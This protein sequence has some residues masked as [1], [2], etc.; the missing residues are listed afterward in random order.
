MNEQGLESHS[1]AFVLR[2]IRGC[3]L[4]DL[5]FLRYD[6]RGAD[7]ENFKNFRPPRSFFDWPAV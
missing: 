4:R 7:N 5:A 3:P 6:S 1:R 2:H